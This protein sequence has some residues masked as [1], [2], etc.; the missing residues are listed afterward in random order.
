MKLSSRRIAGGF[1]AA[2]AL[3]L[4]IWAYL[5]HARSEWA[6]ADYKKQLRA[7]GEPLSVDELLPRPADLDANGARIFQ[8][9][10][11]FFIA[12]ASLLDSNPPAAMWMVAPGKAMVGWKQPDLRDEGANTWEQAEAELDR[13]REALE[14][15]EQISERPMLDFHLDYHQGFTLLLP[16]LSRF[17][18]AALRLK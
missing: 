1:G 4:G 13:E 18:Q 15:L 2:C 16:H 11:R 7:A 17:K 12:G 5:F 10:Q 9:A 14:L 6:L 8:Q 3:A